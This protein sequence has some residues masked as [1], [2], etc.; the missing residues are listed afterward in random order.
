MAPAVAA[1]LALHAPAFALAPAAPYLPC[2]AQ[3]QPMAR[4]EAVMAAVRPSVATANLAPLRHAAAIALPAPPQI[5]REPFAAA[6]PAGRAAPEAVEPGRPAAQTAAPVSME[7]APCRGL[8]LCP[9][10]AV[11]GSVPSFGKPVAAP[12]PAA[13]ESVLV[14]SLAAP[15]APTASARLLPFALADQRGRALPGFDARLLTPPQR[16]IELGLPRPGVLPLE[17]HSH[18]PR[19]ATVA[20]PEWLSPRPALLPPRFLLCPI[21]EKLENPAPRQKSARKESGLVE[22]PNLHAAKRPPAVLM[23]AGRVAAGFL[24]AASLYY[25]LAKFHGERRPA[26]HDEVSSAE[27]TLPAAGSTRPARISNGGTPAGPAPKGAIAWVRRTLANRASL[28]LAEDF[29]GMENWA[30]ATKAHPAGWS[31]HPDGYVNTGALALFRPSLQ[32]TDCHMEFFGQIETKSIGWTVRATDA[33]NYHAMKLTVVEAGLRP[34]VALVQYNVVG[35]KSGPRAETPLNIMVHN[36]RPM[37]FAVDVRGNRVVTS[38]DGE[39]VDSFVDD[40]R[41]AGGVGFFSEAGERA[42]LYWMRVSRNDDWLGHVC[43]MLSDG[44]GGTSTAGLRWPEL[45]G[46][47]GM[48]LAAMWTGRPHLG[49]ARKT[50]F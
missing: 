47:D 27:A 22:L 29:H 1:P 18:R 11:I 28:N 21:L 37:Q 31:R 48:M 17:F 14:A 38:I 36:H 12:A 42:R 6:L 8:T 46:R 4:A 16:P 23:V 9:P 26:A 7:H 44:A 2:V 45:P 15:L 25:G 35:G 10:P 40:T 34:F 49:A 50:G 41:V 24:L 3:A 20:H 43:A 5:F 32:F 30:G 33:L 13:V 39:E 19:S